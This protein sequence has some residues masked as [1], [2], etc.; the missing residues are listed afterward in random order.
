MSKAPERGQMVV[1]L[2][3][4]D[5][6]SGIIHS[7]GAA[8]EGV[9]ELLGVLRLREVLVPPHE[10]SVEVAVRLGLDGH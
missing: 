8:V 9:H 2:G 5:M 10:K 7:N 6:T 1:K 4:L 3:V